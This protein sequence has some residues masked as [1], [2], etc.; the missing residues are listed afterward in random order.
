ML[1][2]GG[3]GGPLVC[4]VST[5]ACKVQSVCKGAGHVC[6]GQG[7]EQQLCDTSGAC[8]CATC[9]VRLASH[10]Q[11]TPPPQP[12]QLRVTVIPQQPNTHHTP[13]TC[14]S[15]DRG[16][17]PETSGGRGPS[18]RPSS[19]S[20]CATLPPLLAASACACCCSCCWLARLTPLLLP[21]P[22]P[23]AAAEEYCW[24]KCRR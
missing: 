6:A 4:V 21:P 17:W 24:Y 1:L 12:T 10:P 3:G 20:P 8:A 23:L 18:S 2:R 5:C 15:V 16:C 19:S 11:P 14:T 7:M 13:R 9:A 22:P